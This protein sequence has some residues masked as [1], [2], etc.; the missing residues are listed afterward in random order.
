MSEDG[1][2]LELSDEQRRARHGFRELVRESIAP[3]AGR[4]DR[5]G[6]I[7][8]EI[9]ELIRERGWLGAPTWV[10]VAWIPSPTAC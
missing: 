1:V 6:K 8:R 2:R 7:P 5:E 10:A 3:H 4:W 9:V